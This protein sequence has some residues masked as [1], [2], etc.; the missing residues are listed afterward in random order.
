MSA[1]PCQYPMHWPTHT[2]AP[3]PLT[4]GPLPP[5]WYQATDPTY[6]HTYYYN[7][8]TGERSWTR[9]AAPVSR[10]RRGVG[11]CGLCVCEG[12]APLQLP[13]H[14]WRHSGE[15][16]AGSRS[17]MAVQFSALCVRSRLSCS[18]AGR[19]MK[20]T[21]VLPAARVLPAAAATRLER[22]Q[23]PCLWCHILLQHS[24]RWVGVRAGLLQRHCS[25]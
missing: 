16:P 9:P 11:A 23:G 25:L 21:P 24:H 4:A 13:L 3:A 2:R 8:S 20:Q 19:M 10:G 17:A 6:S 22:G 18:M 5:G 1:V 12:P 14:L 7:P 15:P